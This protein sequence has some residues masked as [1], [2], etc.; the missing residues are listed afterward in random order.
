MS[1]GNAKISREVGYDD[2]NEAFRG[3]KITRDGLS[4]RVVSVGTAD[5]GYTFDM[6]L[7]DDD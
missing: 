5:V 2:V 4:F 6:E 1:D 7:V 3:A